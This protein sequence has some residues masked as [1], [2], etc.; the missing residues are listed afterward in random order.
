MQAA[1]GRAV[2]HFIKLDFKKLRRDLEVA[3]EKDG[4][5]DAA[6]QWQLMDDLEPKYKKEI[7]DY[8]STI[9]R[10]LTTISH[11]SIG[12]MLLDLINPQQ[13]VWI[14]PADWENSIATT[15]VKTEAQGGGIRISFNP[16]AFRRVTVSPH[17]TANEVEDTL[18]HELVHAMRFSQ[19]RFFR[20]SVTNR[21]FRDSEE[22]IATQFENIYH[23]S[24]RES[25]LYGSY[26]GSYMRKE[27][28]YQ[29]LVEDAELVMA[30]KF[31]LKTE[32]LAQ[33]AAKLQ[34]P[35]YN[36]FRDFDKIEARSLRHFGI[37]KFMDFQ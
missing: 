30:L 26:Y 6:M 27:E 34:Q 36:P 23:S 19:N 29:Y 20:K 16:K 5:I 11:T 35:D 14:I 10:T 2:E 31:F 37:D 13:K 18:F 15:E 32:I 21:D 12:R 28:M 17:A 8:E 22:F 9:E 25:D 33:T 24:R 3:G 7:Q 1:K 4:L